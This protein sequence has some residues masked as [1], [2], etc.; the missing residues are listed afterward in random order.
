MPFG[1]LYNILHEQSGSLT[2]TRRL[3]YGSF[4]GVVVDHAQALKFALD[5]ARGMSFLHSL[6][7]LILRFYLSSKHV[8]VD[9]DLSAKISMADTKFSFQE[10][11]R[12]Y[13]PAWMSPEG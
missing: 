9:E 7:P 10:V 6:D 11:G 1:S 2:H 8:V 5:V 4:A 12:I 3:R 13:S